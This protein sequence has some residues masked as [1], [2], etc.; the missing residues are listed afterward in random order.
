MD[1]IKGAK[2]VIR[3]GAKFN[4]CVLFNNCKFN[5]FGS[6]KRTPTYWTIIHY[7]LK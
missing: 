2:K 3:K 7:R 5:G 4:M 1:E 6:T